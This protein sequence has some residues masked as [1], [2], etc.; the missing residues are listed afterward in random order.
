MDATLGDGL[1]D[2]DLLGLGEA[3]QLAGL[4]FGRLSEHVFTEGRCHPRGI[5]ELVAPPRG[6]PELSLVVGAPRRVAEGQVRLA[7]VERE[8][9]RPKG[10]SIGLDLFGERAGV[11]L[12]QA[13]SNPGVTGGARA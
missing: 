2:L 5:E 3:G 4:S 8:E 6:L 13:F 7:F 12:R 1:G 9:L 10:R 11:L